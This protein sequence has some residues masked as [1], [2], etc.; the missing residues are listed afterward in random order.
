MGYTSI[1]GWSRMSGAGS[2]SGHFILQVDELLFHVFGELEGF[3]P[4]ERLGPPLFPAL[5]FRYF[6]LQLTHLK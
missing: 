1:G 5:R 3:A 6:H 4:F 2:E